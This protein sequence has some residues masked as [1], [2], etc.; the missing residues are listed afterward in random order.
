MIKNM[1]NHEMPDKIYKLTNNLINIKKDPYKIEKVHK[2][3][4]INLTI[5]INKN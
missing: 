3:F 4:K 5:K 1:P 2:H